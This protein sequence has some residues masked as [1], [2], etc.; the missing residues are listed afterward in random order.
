MS[1]V[2]LTRFGVRWV[3]AGQLIAALQ[4]CRL[5]LMRAAKETQSLLGLSA[6]SGTGACSAGRRAGWTVS[7]KLVSECL[8]AK[9]SAEKCTKCTVGVGGGVYARI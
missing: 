7:G 9:S 3:V 6:E 2:H 8:G 5:L 4:P 1:R